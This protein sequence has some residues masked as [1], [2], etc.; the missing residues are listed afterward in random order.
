MRE[1]AAYAEA[2][3]ARISGDVTN[4]VTDDTEGFLPFPAFPVYG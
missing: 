1:P 3:P 2:F 4:R